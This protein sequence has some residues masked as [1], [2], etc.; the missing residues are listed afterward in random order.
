MRRYGTVK[1]NEC[2]GAV[3]FAASY[4]YRF[5]ASGKWYGPLGSL[6]PTLSAMVATQLR[7]TVRV[8]VRTSP[9]GVGPV[10]EERGG[11]VRLRPCLVAA[12]PQAQ[13][14]SVSAHSTGVTGVLAAVAVR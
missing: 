1:G 5:L 14:I 8:R 4:G 12:R 13:A 11:A 3:A 6:L 7:A 9:W 2:C 10:C